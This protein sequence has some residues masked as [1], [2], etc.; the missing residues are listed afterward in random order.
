MPAH[1]RPPTQPLTHP[2]K[3]E[4][5]ADPQDFVIKHSEFPQTGLVQ[6]DCQKCSHMKDLLF[7]GAT[8]ECGTAGC[9]FY[10]FKKDKKAHVYLTH[11][12]LNQGGFK[13]LPEKHHGMNDLLVYRHMSA[14]EG[15]LTR[16][17]FDGNHY[18]SVGAKKN[19]KSADFEKVIQPESV[20][21]ISIPMPVDKN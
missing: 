11:A 18:Q 17:E 5:T 9:N 10:L 20:S 3:G 16:E 1:A 6:F 4:K 2:T 15:I 13:F 21:Q 7:V 12:F 19:V 8:A 14:T